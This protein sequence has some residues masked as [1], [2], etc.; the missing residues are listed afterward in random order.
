MMDRRSVLARCLAVSVACTLALYAYS[1]SVSPRTLPISEIGNDDV[2][3]MVRTEGHV[4]SVESLSSGGV[5]LELIDYSDFASIPVYIPSRT[6]AAIRFSSSIV[7]GAFLRVAGEV[8]EFRGEVEVAVSDASTVQLLSP[9]HDN[10]VGLGTLALNPDTFSGMQVLARGE[11]GD[12]VPLVDR[13]KIMIAS[14]G[15]S[16]WVE[17][18]GSG[19]PRGKVDV[20]GKVSLDERR[21]R[22]EIMAVGS[23]DG[24]LPHPSP[25]PASHSVVSLASLAV[26]PA[27]LEGKLVAVLNVTALA[28]EV[29]GTSFS[30][31]DFVDGGEYA[32]SCMAFDWNWQT[33]S[34][35]ITDG[36]IVGFLGVW[37]YY[38]ARAQWQVTSDGFNLRP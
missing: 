13:S 28:G 14:G 22:F 34:R 37:W 15:D 25:V 36:M 35:G 2:G 12:I 24:I 26:D 18:S 30:L 23:S 9:A 8:Q 3:A 38:E 10:V 27:A 1:W 33:D 16:L 7:P 5:K 31:S 6:L 17:F 21:D 20:F 29:I 32:V 4:R 11:I 19:I